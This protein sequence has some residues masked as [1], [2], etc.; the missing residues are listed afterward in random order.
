MNYNLLWREYFYTW[1]TEPINWLMIHKTRSL[2][3]SLVI[4]LTFHGTIQNFP[5]KYYLGCKFNLLNTEL[6]SI[7]HLLALLGAH[8]NLHVSGVR[9][10]TQVSHNKICYG[11][12]TGL[13]WH[14]CKKLLKGHNEKCSGNHWISLFSQKHYLGKGGG[15]SCWQTNSIHYNLQPI[16]QQSV[17]TSNA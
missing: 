7:C 10:K 2:N 12:K 15:G 5:P 9:V 1:I 13:T 8:H 4:L 14:Q 11:H 16:C 17:H 3:P 6:N